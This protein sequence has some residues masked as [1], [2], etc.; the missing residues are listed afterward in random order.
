M[1]RFLF[2]ALLILLPL[3]ARAQTEQQSVVDRATLAIQDML[4]SDVNREAQSLIRKAKGA[5]VCPQVFKA[6]F[7]FGGVQQRER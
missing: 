4:G 1:T 2:A 3:T 7:I 5:M 6:G